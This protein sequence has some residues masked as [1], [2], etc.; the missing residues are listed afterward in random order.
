MFNVDNSLVASL[1]LVEM[2]FL[3]EWLDFLEWPF[4]WCEMDFLCGVDFLWNVPVIGQTLLTL[5]HGKIRVQAMSED[6]Y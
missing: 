5:K 2:D 4:C 3:L 6:K 1:A